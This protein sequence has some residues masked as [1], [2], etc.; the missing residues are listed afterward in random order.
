MSASKTILAKTRKALTKQYGREATEDEALEAYSFMKLLAKIHV[1]YAIA[2]CQRRQKLKLN[3]KGFPLE[4]DGPN[5][6]IC[7]DMTS[8][9]NSWYDAN[10]VKCLACQ[11]AIDKEI[12]PVSLC[13]DPESY[14]SEFELQIF[15]SLKGK[16]LNSLIKRGAIKCRVIPATN[17]RSAKKLFL[18]SDNEGFFPPHHL[19]RSQM[20]KETRDGKE[21]FVSAPWYWC[22]DD[23]VAHLFGYG[24]SEYLTW[25]AK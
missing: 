9:E 5:C 19:V 15:F 21:E 17:R 1:N 20:V 7:H 16:A 13:K 8:R 6:C 2:E 12:I 25:V 4:V 14:Y 10:G 22:C 3:P 11:N 24:I 23:P 18:F